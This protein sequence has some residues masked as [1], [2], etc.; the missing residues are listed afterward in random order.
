MSLEADVASLA[1]ATPFGLLPHE[2]LRLIAYASERRDLKAGQTL[3]RAGDPGDSAYLIL[4]GEILLNARN[5]ERIAGRGVL[6][7]ETALL[8]DGE[9]IATARVLND[10]SLLCVP[11]EVFRRV[12]GEFPD[13]AVKVRARIAARTRAL[14]NSLETLRVEKF[15][16]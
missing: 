1:R 2:A 16:P 3:F 9:R 10:A 15:A 6:I 4:E 12:L 8:I 14:I 11:R 5:A 7:G 13:A